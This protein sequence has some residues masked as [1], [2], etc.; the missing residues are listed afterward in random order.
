MAIIFNTKTTQRINQYLSKFDNDTFGYTEFYNIEC[1]EN[2]KVQNF[3]CKE[4][5]D[6]FWRYDRFYNYRKYTLNY[7]QKELM[8]EIAKFKQCDKCGDWNKIYYNK[9]DN[10]SPCIICKYRKEKKRNLLTVNTNH[11]LC[12]EIE[13]CPICVDNIDSNID[14]AVLTNCN[15]KFHPDCIK[16]WNNKKAECPLCR[17][18]TVKSKFIKQKKIV[19]E[20]VVVCNKNTNTYNP[21][22]DDGISDLIWYDN[23]VPR[24]TIQHFPYDYRCK[25]FE[26][27]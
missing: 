25:L 8:K 24:F 17:K 23:F 10:K 14:N 21:N 5:E 12:G 20:N 13:T 7:Y 3:I 26:K 22:H 18:S 16:S 27:N 6:R 4:L 11:E 19:T 2:K 15:H 9:I 1:N